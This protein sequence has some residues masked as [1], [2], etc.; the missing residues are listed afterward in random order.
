ME[1]STLSQVC[2]ALCY[3]YEHQREIEQDI[4]RNRAALHIGPQKASP[5]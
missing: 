1:C 2:A 5:A 4:A 3:S